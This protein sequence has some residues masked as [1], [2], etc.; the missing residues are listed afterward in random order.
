MKRFICVLVLTFATWA[1]IA[2]EIEYRPGG[3]QFEKTWDKFY[4]GDHE[5]ELSDPLIAVGSKMTTAICE[6]VLHIDMRLR[7]YAIG[8]LGFIGDKRALPTLEKILKNKKE[9]YYVR[10]DALNAIYQLDKERGAK[11]AKQFA[12]EHE[13][14]KMM[15]DAIQKEAKW[16]TTRP[17]H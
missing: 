1:C 5:P 11:F 13:Y 6:A 9:L 4:A 7:R 2:E 16:L 17:K 15:A 14:L 12:S 10:G 3:Q 8:A